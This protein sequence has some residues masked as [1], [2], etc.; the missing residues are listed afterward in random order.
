MTWRHLPFQWLAT[1]YVA[2]ASMALFFWIGRVFGPARFGEYSYAL[3]LAALAGLLFDAGF[4]TLI[5]REEI[6]GQKTGKV[7]GQAFGH[8]ILLTGIGAI[9]CI[10]SPGT[11][12]LPLSAILAF[13]VTNTA[14]NFYSAHLKAQGDFRA[15]A[16]WQIVC[17]TAS[18]LFIIAALTFA[19]EPAMVFWGWAVGLGLC[20]MGVRHWLFSHTLCF[21]I[22]WIK[23]RPILALLLIDLATTVY[24]R[25]DVVLL[26]ALGISS[27]EI[28][29]YSIAYKVL[30]G[31]ILLAAPV[32]Q[33][34]FREMRLN[35]LAGELFVGRLFSASLA[36]AA[37]A[38]A[39][40]GLTVLGGEQLLA[41]LLGDAYRGTAGVL[42]W[43]M[44]GLF[45]IL[46]NALLT[47]AAL[48]ADREWAYARAAAWAAAANVALNLLLIPEHG[49]VGAA[50]ATI[51]TE[52][53]LM[54]GLIYGVGFWRN[55]RG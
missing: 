39:L 27:A 44:L 4:K 9:V 49:I 5:F 2:G 23:Y 32:A 8:L 10:L 52:A 48:A 24:F 15:E 7:A 11:V 16:A 38:A 14:V 21:R 37:L 29:R 31:F 40:A 28:G 12:S 13:L 35:W 36:S 1:L 6:G 34:F 45:F 19:A 33:I 26:D 53:V 55:T 51:A 41:F 30:E 47:Q 22:D 42:S 50:W 43:L 18:A 20:L 46:P 25:I 54:I 3:T 17:R